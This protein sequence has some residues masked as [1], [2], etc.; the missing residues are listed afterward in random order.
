M[1]TRRHG[2]GVSI[3]L[4][5]VL[6]AF[7]LMQSGCVVRT[8]Q[9]TKERT[10]Q[11]LGGGNRGLMQGKN[12][13]GSL[14]ERKLTRTLQAIEIEMHPLIKFK[15]SPR[16]KKIQQSEPEAGKEALESGLG[17]Q[18]QNSGAA[19]QMRLQPYTVQKG[20]TLQKIS[21]KFFGTSKKWMGIYEANKDVLKS[22]NKVFPGQEIQIPMEQIPV[23]PERLK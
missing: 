9:V 19:A 22:P 14:K 2:V 23:Q 15:K 7:T 4:I 20:D 16:Q 17:P 21:Q 18:A 13:D 11:D 10:D 1:N 8:Y 3:G 12:L 6:S 5:T